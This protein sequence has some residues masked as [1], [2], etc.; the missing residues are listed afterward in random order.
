MHPGCYNLMAGFSGMLDPGKKVL[1]VGSFDVN[2]TFRPLFSAHEYTGTDLAAGPNVDVIQPDAFT[3]PFPDGFFDVVI[4]GNMLEHCTMPWKIV[5]EMDRV[6]KPGG[7]MAITTPWSIGYHAYPVDCWRLSPDAMT[8]LF[9][10]WMTENRRSPYLA[11]QNR[12]DG[13]DTFYVGRKP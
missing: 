13:I 5:L 8:V 4:S 10:A 12:F 7:L 9:G 1:D 6:L 2:G 11:L 3:L